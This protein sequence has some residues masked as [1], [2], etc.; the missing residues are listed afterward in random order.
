MDLYISFV[1]GI[2]VGLIFA[3]IVRPPLFGTLRIDRSNPEKD[4]YRFE[5]DNFDDLPSYKKITLKI[6]DKANLSQN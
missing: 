6:D 5:I 4:M 1:L 3:V 2:L